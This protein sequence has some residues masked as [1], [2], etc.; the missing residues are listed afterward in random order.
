M[1]AI[2]TT[3]GSI[4]TSA[5]TWIGDFAGVFTTTGNE[6]LLI[7]VGLAVAGFGIGALRRLFSVR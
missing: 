3:V 4:V 7:P 2:L 6:I 1:E 5:V